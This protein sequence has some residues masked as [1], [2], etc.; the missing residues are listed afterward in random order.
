MVDM[1]IFYLG[2]SI[3]LLISLIGSLTMFFHSMERQ[4]KAHDLEKRSLEQQQQLQAEIIR[5][6]TNQTLATA[7]EISAFLHDEII[8]QR[9]LP[10]LTKLKSLTKMIQSKPQV[11]KNELEDSLWEIIEAIKD[12]NQCLRDM[13]NTVLPSNLLHYFSKSL[14]DNFEQE[15]RRHITDLQEKIPNKTTIDTQIEGNFHDFQDNPT[16]LYQIYAVVDGFVT[17]SLQKAE[18]EKISIKLWR[19]EE[20]IEIDLNDNG[21]GFDFNNLI[22]RRGHQGLSNLIINAISLSPNYEFTSTIGK[23]TNLKISINLEAYEY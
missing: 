23:G 1:S 13:S 16:L 11:S 15:I 22:I 8:N 18:A 17:N 10:H 21:K 20:K 14:V 5:V 3:I 19:H 9:M 2:L 7:R 4:R 12:T 6:Q